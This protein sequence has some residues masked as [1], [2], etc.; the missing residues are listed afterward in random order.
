MRISDWCSDG[1]SSDLD[2]TGPAAA[3][4]IEVAF[5]ALLPSAVHVSAP[6]AAAAPVVS[7]EERRVGEEGVS[8]CRS[9]QSPYDYKNTQPVLLPFPLLPAT[10]LHTSTV[11]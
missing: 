7:S 11:S 1:C 6:N 10:A 3:R 5:R 4:A 9:R 2:M 8:T